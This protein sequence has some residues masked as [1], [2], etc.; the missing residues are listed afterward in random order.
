MNYRDRYFID[1]RWIACRLFGT[2][3]IVLAT[4]VLATGCGRKQKKDE[5]SHS[6]TNTLPAIANAIGA[7]TNATNKTVHSAHDAVVTPE[8]KKNGISSNR[9]WGTNQTH[10]KTS[11]MVQI[12]AGR[13]LMGDPDQADAPPHEVIVS[14]FYMDKNLVTQQQYRKVMGANPSRW[15]GDKNPV[16]Q[17]RWSD[18]VK[19]C[20]KLSQQERLTPCYNLTNWQCDFEANGYRL[21]TEAEWE[22]ACR[23]G[24]TTPFFFGR[25]S[26]NLGNYAWF[27]RNSDGHPNPVGKK[28]PNP[29]GLYDI[30]GNVW[31][32]CN[33]IYT[34]EY[35]RE[36]LQ[37][38]PKGPSKG[39][40]RVVRGGGF[41]FRDETCRSGY[42]SSENP[43][44]NEV[45]FGYDIYG[46][47][48]VRKVDGNPGL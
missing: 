29:W 24:T 8:S 40:G 20:N 13:F 16:E 1:T 2:A 27:D 36:S 45:C 47:R 37:C 28:E 10:S 22:Y 5:L 44:Y 17:V 32:W 23:A 14:S 30:T 6:G 15:K 34:A 9:Y 18:A 46:F 39:K 7:V 25:T 3:L 31:Q 35:Y 42:R 12:P 38:D 19:Y 43:G 26:D 41:R 4:M 21:P 11:E 33:D 48:C